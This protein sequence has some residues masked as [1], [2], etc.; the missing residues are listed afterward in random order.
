V[1]LTF[2][3]RRNSQRRDLPLACKLGAIDQVKRLLEEFGVSVNEA[4]S[5]GFT[6]LLFAVQSGFS[7]ITE[8]LLTVVL[9]RRLPFRKM[10][11][12]TES[13]FLA[14]LASIFQSFFKLGLTH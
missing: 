4:G 10:H 2:R 8:L 9:L 3:D 14:R 11:L 6:P 7:K 5:D 1:A 13:V 12:Q